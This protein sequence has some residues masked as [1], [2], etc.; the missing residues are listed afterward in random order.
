MTYVNRN[1]T[2][3]LHS[4][5]RGKSRLMA[6]Y[7][8]LDMICFPIRNRHSFFASASLA[9]PKIPIR[10]NGYIFNGQDRPS[11]SDLLKN[12]MHCFKI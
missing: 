1:H 12:L 8:I 4:G 3:Q 10:D 9:K 2:C 7:K 5:A 6:N 11:L